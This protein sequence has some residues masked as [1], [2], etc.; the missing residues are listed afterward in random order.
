MEQFRASEGTLNTLNYKKKEKKQW[1]G[2][3]R[4]LLCFYNFLKFLES[5][6]SFIFDYFSIV[7]NGSMRVRRTIIRWV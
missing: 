2:I 5:K 1:R 7:N 3:T 4:R 6:L